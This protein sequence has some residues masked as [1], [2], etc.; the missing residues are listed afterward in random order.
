MYRRLEKICESNPQIAEILDKASIIKV[1][2]SD[3][4][5]FGKLYK[6]IYGSTWNETLVNVVRELGGDDV[7]LLH[8]FSILPIIY[9]QKGL[10]DVFRFLDAMQ[11]D[12]T[13]I[14]KCSEKLYDGTVER[15]M[16]RL[17]DVVLR[18]ERTEG[19]LLGFG[20]S[21]TIRVDQ[22]IV[23]DIE[24]GAERFEIGEDGRL[25]EV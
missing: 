18:V 24:P 7:L 6:H 15:I 14:G 13:V 5:S 21:Y 3:E 8:G 17:Y 20:E 19:E 1:G 11:D 2:S 25:V 4:I 10:I 22:T 16:E 9:G 23:T 12:V